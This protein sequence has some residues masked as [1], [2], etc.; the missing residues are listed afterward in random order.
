M[1]KKNAKNLSPQALFEFI[2]G[3]F[4]PK[5]ENPIPDNQVLGSSNYQTPTPMPTQ[6][7]LPT[8]TP[9]PVPTAIPTPLPITP[10]QYVDPIM[11]A[12]KKYDIPANFLSA[13]LF[14]E[15]SYN[16]DVISGKKK[17]KAGAQGIA[18]LM[19][20]TI[21]ELERLKYGTVDPF[22]PEQA[23]PAAAFYMDQMRKQ[24]GRK[25][26]SLEDWIEAAKAYNAGA[27]NYR[28]YKG[29]IP[30]E[31]TKKYTEKIIKLLES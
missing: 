3:F 8:A 1:A 11:A 12:S 23:I 20:E 6:I 24:T 28:K 27:G 13:Q 25:G 19:P 5:L 30:F 16:P 2:S 31:E 21:K 9:T 10:K 15:S 7:P 17:S 18:Q 4:S 29:D 26:T 14:T 22:D